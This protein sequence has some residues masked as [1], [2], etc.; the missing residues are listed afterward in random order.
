[1]TNGVF[2]KGIAGICCLVVAAA[3]V[4]AEQ[5]KGALGDPE[6]DA[7]SVKRSYWPTA[8]RSP[9]TTFV[10]GR[11][12][13]VNVTLRDLI[14]TAFKVSLPAIQIVGGPEWM[15]SSRFDVTATAPSVDI[16]GL[17]AR[18]RRLLADRFSLA[19]RSET[20]SLPAFRLI[21]ARTDGKLASGLRE[22]SCT[23][24]RSVQD[25]PPCSRFMTGANVLIGKN[26]TMKQFA[27]MI[28]QIKN[29]TDVDR[30]VFDETGLTGMYTFELRYSPARSTEGIFSKPDPNL[31][32]FVTAI[33]EQFGLKLESTIGPVPIVAIERASAP[34]P[35]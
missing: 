15:D 13:A 29:D 28:P 22:T 26:V 31:P 35:D 1:M 3:V 20:R 18:L 25:A 12:L 23:E 11:V 16:E 2:L 6:F 17:R 24:D 27:L 30:Y 34:S 10:Q 21:K 19:A 8:V 33:R 7:A 4:C 5:N 32:T 14:Q 9:R